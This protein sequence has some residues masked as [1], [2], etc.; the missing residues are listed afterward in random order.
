MLMD[1]LRN[2]GTEVIWTNVLIDENGVPHWVGNGEK[3]P[4]K[5][6]NFQGEWF[7]GKVDEA[8]KPIPL[9][10]PNSRCT[11]SSTAL[12]NYSDKTEAPEGVETRVITYSG[13]DSD[14]MPPVWAAKN[15]D[16]GVVI[17]ACIVSAATATEVGATGVKRAPWANAPFIPGA[18]GDYMKAQFDF[19]GNAAIADGKRP[20]LAGLNYFLTHEARGGSGKKLLGEKKDVKVWLGWLERR[21]HGD[22]DAIET[23]IGF[24][25]RYDD[26]KA[27]FETLI[28]KP[29]P[30]ASLRPAVFPL[31]GQHPGPKRPAD[32]RLRQGG[33]HSR[34][35]VR[36]ASGAAGRSDCPE[37]PV[38]SR[39]QAGATIGRT[40]IHT[41]MTSEQE[42]GR[43]KNHLPPLFVYPLD[44]SRK[45][46][47]P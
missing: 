7:A 37:D 29:Y 30:K 25:P 21:T 19:F 26:L 38:R 43:Q 6:T 10:H 16:H 11:L 39:C 5:G 24:I 46:S 14:T 13:R 42:L 22:V 40:E 27:L 28:D 31:C 41:F 23:P 15:A 45:E 32:R 3:P 20:I 8:G 33:K 47:I 34:A 18:L 9:S 1:C 12:A 17:G 44:W 36:C 35:A 2:E 4:E